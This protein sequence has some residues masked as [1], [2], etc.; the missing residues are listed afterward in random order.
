MLRIGIVRWRGKCSRHPSFDPTDGPGTTAATCE[1]CGKLAEILDHQRKMIE[2]MRSFAPPR[3]RKR[4][5][6]DADRQI[7]LFDDF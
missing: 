2:L 4:L 1:R 7:S 3:E 5:P 6:S